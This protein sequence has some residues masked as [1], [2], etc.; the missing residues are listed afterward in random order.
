MCWGTSHSFTHIP[1][2]FAE[3]KKKYI[4]SA[5]IL[6]RPIISALNW[7]HM[8]RKL[9]N[10]E[11][12]KHLSFAEMQ[13]HP[14]TPLAPFQ[15]G[16]ILCVTSPMA[17][18]HPHCR[19]TTAQLS[20]YRAKQNLYTHSSFKAS[21]YQQKTLSFTGYRHFLKIFSFSTENGKRDKWRKEAKHLDKVIQG[22]FRKKA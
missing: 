14:N 18:N 8:L 6:R 21:Q 7:P 22:A 12:E 16:S 3:Q 1:F 19:Q 11:A 5:S 13:I 20:Y 4:C 17:K 2:C 9:L 10:R 15:T